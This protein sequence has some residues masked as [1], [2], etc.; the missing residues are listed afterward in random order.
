MRYGQKLSDLYPHP[1]KISLHLDTTHKIQL[2]EKKNQRK[3]ALIQSRKH[4]K[5]FLSLYLLYWNVGIHSQSGDIE[6][7]EPEEK[8]YKKIFELMD[9]FSSMK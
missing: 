2:E 4:L 5:S 6:I 8:E 7:I 1:K 3:N 9:L